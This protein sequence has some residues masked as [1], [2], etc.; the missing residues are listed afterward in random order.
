MFSYLIKIIILIGLFIAQS[1]KYSNC[2]YL[3][4]YLLLLFNKL[5]VNLIKIIVYYEYTY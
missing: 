3:P 1:C 5:F 2:T 4:D